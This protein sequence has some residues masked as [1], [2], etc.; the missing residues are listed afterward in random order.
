MTFLQLI[1]LLKQYKFFVALLTYRKH[2]KMHITDPLHS[3]RTWPVSLYIN[4]IKMTVETI[5]VI[6][7]SPSGN[8][9]TKTPN[10]RV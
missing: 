3:L 9:K 5:L 7:Q 2:V 4:A 6:P 1:P 10:I 8:R